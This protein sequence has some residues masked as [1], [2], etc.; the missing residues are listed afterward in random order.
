[1]NTR[2]AL[3]AIGSALTVG[4]FVVLIACCSRPTDESRRFAE[5]QYNATLVVIENLTCERND[6]D[7]TDGDFM[8]TIKIDAPVHM[9]RG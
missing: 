1:M 6:T 2:N 7:Q 4:L 3:R 9:Y 5:I 8:P